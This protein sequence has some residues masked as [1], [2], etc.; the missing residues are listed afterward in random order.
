MIR[1]YHNHNLHKNTSFLHG[2]TIEGCDHL[3]L[4]PVCRQ[5]LYRRAAKEEVKLT[6]SPHVP[7]FGH[8]YLKKR[9]YFKLR[10]K[11]LMKTLNYSY[12]VDMYACILPIYISIKI[13]TTYGSCNW[14]VLLGTCSAQ[15]PFPLLPKNL[16]V[17]TLFYN[18]K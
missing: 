11:L 12:S 18:L 1:K 5:T 4:G 16:I 10:K 2:R 7:I 9:L 3:F 13:P 8:S 17:N 15:M 14:H 6:K